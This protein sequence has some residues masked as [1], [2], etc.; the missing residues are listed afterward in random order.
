MTT[1]AD[2]PARAARASRGWSAS[3]VVDLLMALVAHG[4]VGAAWAV[5]AVAAMGSLGVLR[6]IPMNS[7][8][9]WDTGRLPQPWVIPLGLIAAWLAHRFFRWAM[10]RVTRGEPAWGPSVVAWCGA[11]L[12]VLVGAYLWVPP[13][14]VG[15]R[16]GPASGQSARWDWLGWV[17]YYARLWLPGLVGLVTLALL[18]VSRN[19]P[20]VVAARSWRRRR[21]VLGAR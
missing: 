17:A 15:V 12:G 6:R 13:L 1:T 21:G 9:A 18:F 4:L 8:F 5:T 10:A 3:R 7:E 2:V 16:V 20:L 19:S 14:Q 11:L